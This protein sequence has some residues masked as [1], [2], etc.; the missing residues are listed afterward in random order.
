MGAE[1]SVETQKLQMM[2][3]D[4]VFVEKFLNLLHKLEPFGADSR[5][6]RAEEVQWDSESKYSFA[7]IFKPNV[8]LSAEFKLNTKLI[9]GLYA[10]ELI[11]ADNPMLTINEKTSIGVAVA[12]SFGNNYPKYFAVMEARKYDYNRRVLVVDNFTGEHSPDA[13][14]KLFA[15]SDITIITVDEIASNITS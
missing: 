2:F 11:V 4:D 12:S 7:Y 1:I 9:G 8:K 13:L 6:S 10:S 14:R 15:R 5:H 3:M